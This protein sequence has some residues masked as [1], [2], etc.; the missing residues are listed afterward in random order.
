[1]G[2]VVQQHEYRFYL[3]NDG[4]RTE[5]SPLG[6]ISIDWELQ[7]DTFFYEKTVGSFK[8]AGSDYEYVKAIEE[9]GDICKTLYVEVDRRCPV[10]S[11]ELYARSKWNIQSC[12]F[13]NSKCNITINP[14][15]LGIGTCLTERASESINIL[16][17]M[18][19]AT[20][21]KYDNLTFISDWATDDLIG[22]DNGHMFYY[23]GAGFDDILIRPQFLDSNGDPATS[24]T[25]TLKPTADELFS[26]GLIPE[27]EVELIAIHRVGIYQDTIADPPYILY[28]AWAYRR[29]E[30]KVLGQCPETPNGYTFINDNPTTC[31]FQKKPEDNDR[32][33]TG[34]NVFDDC[35]GI[36]IIPADSDTVYSGA[37]DGETGIPVGGLCLYVIHKDTR[38][39]QTL[40]L[41]NLLQRFID[42]C[43]E[44]K[45]PVSDFFQIN[46]EN[47][48]GTNYVTGLPTQ[49]SDIRF[50]Q[51][52]DA[53]FFVLQNA[54]IGLMSWGDLATW[55]RNSYQVYWSED[56]DGN[57]RLEHYSF[58]ENIT[59]GIDATTGNK[60]KHTN[61]RINYTY[62]KDLLPLI[63]NINDDG[64]HHN[65]NWDAREIR[66]VDP[67]G[68][69][70]PCV[71]T[72]SLE[73]SHGIFNSDLEFFIEYPTQIDR[74][75]WVAIACRTYMGSDE[76][77][78]ED[79]LLNGSMSIKRLVERYYNHGRSALLGKVNGADVTFESS[80]KIKEEENLVFP[81]CCD[82]DFDPRFNIKTP[83]GIGRTTSASH[84]LKTNKLSTNNE[85]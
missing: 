49:T 44:D 83:N 72:S 22:Y 20:G 73:R 69:K 50:I 32:S 10:T 5:I 55:L 77:I 31:F 30:S 36:G 34:A 26:A 38:Q 53:I 65:Y 16:Q 13:Q 39:I 18:I 19:D 35:A 42:L 28:V 33:V 4:S 15:S 24:G 6:T 76:V 57:L 59:V 48:S 51:R 2:A 27:E 63:E 43:D 12:R 9:A 84:E 80:I 8:V 14:E 52:S 61:Q 78:Y 62:K 71:G 17:A 47:P 82:D 68:D 29:A 60:A 1:M 74:A 7:D 75:G 81:L 25:P 11:W 3:V 85:Y 21:F 58:Y 67:S 37:L 45:I 40:S 54:N 56:S 64:N 70:L 66:Y 23:S 79:G 41:E 46:P